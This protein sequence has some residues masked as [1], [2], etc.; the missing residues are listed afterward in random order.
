[1]TPNLPTVTRLGILE[2]EA[3]N[4]A[5]SEVDRDRTGARGVPTVKTEPK[6]AT[7]NKAGRKRLTP[8]TSLENIPATFCVWRVAV[9]WVSNG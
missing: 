2:A 4:R 7:Y 6:K 8:L 1:M 5:Q 9:L 3:E